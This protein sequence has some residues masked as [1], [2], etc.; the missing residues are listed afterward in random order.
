M[1]RKICIYC[2]KRKNPN[3]FPKHKLRPDGLDTRCKKCLRHQ[4]KVRARLHKKAPPKPENCECCLQP[5][6]LKKKWRL[7]HDHDTHEFRGWVCEN[8]NFGIGQLGD[9]IPGLIRALNYLLR[10]R[11]RSEKQYEQQ[12]KRTSRRK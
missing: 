9:D 2:K 12:D 1:K 11:S 7:D 8:C 6:I 4:S 3:S 5:V 10:A